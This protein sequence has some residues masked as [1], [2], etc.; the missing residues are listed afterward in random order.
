MNTKHRRLF[1]ANNRRYQYFFG[2]SAF[3]V[4]TLLFLKKT[5]IRI[6]AA[7]FYI[8]LNSAA[9]AATNSDQFIQAIKHQALSA[10]ALA[11][12]EVKIED[13]IVSPAPFHPTLI[14]KNCSDLNFQPQGQR[15]VGRLTGKLNCHAPNWS[16]YVTYEVAVF[17][18][19]VVTSEAISRG[20]SIQASQLTT[21]RAD[22]GL[23]KTGYF[24]KIEDVVGF[25]AR[26]TLKPGL[27]VTNYIAEPPYL[28]EKGDWVTIVSGSGA[29]K[30]TATGEA[31][32]SGRYGEQITIRN[33]SSKEKIKAW[34]IKKGTVSTRK[35][36]F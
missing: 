10:A 8:V 31:L 21:R 17:D 34:I 3:G 36:A 22:V 20:A 14:T 11:H 13:I 16:A 27:V 23:L 6:L 30:V 19:I 32:N 1:Q 12:P 2:L 35:S 18:D 29:I 33:L 4:K 24:R 26:R 9:M 28:V 5:S 25:T 15:V 7:A